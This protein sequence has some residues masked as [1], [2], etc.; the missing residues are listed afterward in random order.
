[1]PDDKTATAIYNLKFFIVVYIYVELECNVSTNC[2]S[3][4]LW[5]D[6]L[7]NT[8]GGVVARGKLR[9]EALVACEGE[10]ILCTNIYAEALDRSN[11]RQL[12]RQCVTY[13]SILQTEVRT[14]VD[15]E[16]R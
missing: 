11:T 5:I 13:L 2:D 3:T 10:E 1:M 4:C 14:I 7:I 8:K 9:I 6:T 12:N 15:I 16:V